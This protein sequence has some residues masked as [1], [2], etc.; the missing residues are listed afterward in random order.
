MVRHTWLAM[1]ALLTAT[2]GLTTY[3]ADSASA[4]E[5]AIVKI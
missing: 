3:A 5:Q 4:D 1:L 2:A